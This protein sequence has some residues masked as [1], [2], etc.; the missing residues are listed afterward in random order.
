M[1]IQWRKIASHF[2]KKNKKSNKKSTNHHVIGRCPPL[3]LLPSWISLLITGCTHIGHTAVAEAKSNLNRLS[4]SSSA[5][6]SLYCC[7]CRH[8]TPELIKQTRR[9]EMTDIFLIIES[10]SV[11]VFCEPSCETHIFFTFW[12]NS[13]KFTHITSPE[14]LT[15]IFHSCS[16]QLLNHLDFSKWVRNIA[17]CFTL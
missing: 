9:Q 5:M 10:F 7:P 12:V 14:R 15:S 4:P 13:G 3:G 2:R 6:H 16:H 8:Y 11:K 1:S 17:W